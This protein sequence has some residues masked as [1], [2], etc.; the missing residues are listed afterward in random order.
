MPN[1]NGYQPVYGNTSIPSLYVANTNGAAQQRYPW[2]QPQQYNPLMSGAMNAVSGIRNVA[3]TLGNSFQELSNLVNGSNARPWSFGDNDDDDDDE[4]D[5][6][7]FGGSRPINRA[8]APYAGYS[9]IDQYQT[10]YDAI[11]NYDPLKTTEEINALLENIRPD[12]ELPPHLRVQ[13]P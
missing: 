1:G 4:D 10:R 11:A 5:D 9:D 3:S 13:T 8:P 12:A 7:I 6:I 2:M